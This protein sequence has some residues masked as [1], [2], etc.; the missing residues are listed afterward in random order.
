MIF[1]GF[2][3]DTGAWKLTTQANRS[4]PINSAII[5]AGTPLA[6]FANGASTT[7]GCGAR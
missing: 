6:A 2:F 4:I 5:A 7:P 3:D 1:Q